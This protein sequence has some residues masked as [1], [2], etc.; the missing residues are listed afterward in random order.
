MNS[1]NN[2]AIPTW[3]LSYVWFLA[4]IPLLFNVMLVYHPEW[5]FQALKAEPAALAMSGPV[6]SYFA[7]NLAT[8]IVTGY[9]GLTRSRDML[10]TAFLLRF[11][12]DMSEM[13]NGLFNPPTADT[14]SFILFSGISAVLLWIPTLIGLVVLYRNRR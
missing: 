11:A 10:F 9:A 4:V 1:Q 6:G 2:T 7:R 12:T 5:L 13:V 14:S 3:I 8:A